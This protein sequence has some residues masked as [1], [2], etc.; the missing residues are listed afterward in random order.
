MGMLQLYRRLLWLSCNLL[1]ALHT[2]ATPQDKISMFPQANFCIQIPDIHF[3]ICYINVIQSDA[4][5]AAGHWKLNHTLKNLGIIQINVMTQ[6]LLFTFIR[7]APGLFESFGFTD[8]KPA[9]I[10]FT[11]FS[12]V[13]APLSE[14][15]TPPPPPPPPRAQGCGPPPPFS[16]N[17]ASITQ[18][19]YFRSCTQSPIQHRS[20][21]SWSL[22]ITRVTC[23]QELPSIL[24]SS[25]PCQHP[26]M[27]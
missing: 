8:V 4:I 21:Q 22:K 19:I 15:S 10:A 1:K 20:Q 3:S 17:T 16:H 11:L 5:L 24:H 6:F 13:S 9:F 12:A 14:V 2:L 26:Q 7:N 18:Q 25:P 27:D 23:K